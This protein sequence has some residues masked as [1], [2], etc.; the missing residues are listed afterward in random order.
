MLF[1]R[2]KWI[3]T[4]DFNKTTWFNN[5]ILSI[6]NALDP[7]FRDN[8]HNVGNI[9]NFS[10]LLIKRKWRVYNRINDFLRE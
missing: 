7:I 8:I 6:S 10:H 3:E 4:N 9:S 5:M 2:V 1:V